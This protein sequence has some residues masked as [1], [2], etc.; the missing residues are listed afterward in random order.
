M[1][2]F[3]KQHAQTLGGVDV[4]G[5][6]ALVLFVMV[7]AGAVLFALKANKEYIQELEQIPFN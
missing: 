6:V 3:I 2:S 7:F 4:F 1:F 5:N